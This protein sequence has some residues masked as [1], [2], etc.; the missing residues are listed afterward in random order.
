M[1]SG[2]LMFEIEALTSVKSLTD[3]VP[4]TG[5]PNETSPF[6]L[7]MLVEPPATTLS[8]ITAAGGV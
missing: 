6:R 5:S 1:A 2:P 7:L 4:V 8:E 3:S